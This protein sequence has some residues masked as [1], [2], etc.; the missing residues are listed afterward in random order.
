[1]TTSKRPTQALFRAEYLSY[2]STKFVLCSVGNG[3][4]LLGAFGTICAALI[5]EGILLRRLFCQVIA[6]A[7]IRGRMVSDIVCCAMAGVL[8]LLLAFLGK[9]ASAAADRMPPVLL[10][11]SQTAGQLPAEESLMRACSAPMLPLKTVLLRAVS[12]E[13]ETSVE[14]LLRPAPYTN[15]SVEDTT[16]NRTDLQKLI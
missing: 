6:P 7:L 5:V 9:Q 10:L 13:Q 11:T 14:D 4:W 2:M 16:V 15:G 3:L 1:M 8:C 12:S